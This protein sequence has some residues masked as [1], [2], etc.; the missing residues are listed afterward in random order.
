MAIGDNLRRLRVNKG[1]TQ[2]ELSSMTGVKLGQISKIERNEADPKVS[3]IY[4]LM[5][6]LDCSADSVFMDKEKT[7]LKGVMKEALEDASKL[8][9]SDQ[10]T[11]L[12]IIHRFCVANGLNTMLKEHRVL[13]DI[14]RSPKEDQSPPYIDE[15]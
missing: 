1:L 15:A 8:P 2:G 4:K 9:E 13:I 5:A 10:K 11:L 7:G 14:S 12:T 3:T 6:S